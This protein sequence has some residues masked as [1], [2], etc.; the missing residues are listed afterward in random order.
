MAQNGRRPC[1]VV[2]RSGI[3]R[4]K[5]PISLVLLLAGALAL[6]GCGLPAAGP[7][8]NSFAAMSADS[9]TPPIAVVD[10]TPRTLASQKARPTMSLAAK[11]GALDRRRIL[12]LEPGDVISLSLWEAP[13]GTL[14]SSSILS[15]QGNLNNTSTITIPSQSVEADGSISVPFAGR[16]FVAGE[17]I[18]AVEEKISRALQG[19][20][21]Q[22]QALVTVVRSSVNTVTVTGE[23]AGGSRVPLSAGGERILDVIAASGGLRAPVH[24]SV[25]ELT[26]QRASARIPFQKLIHSP[27]EN[28]VLLPG[29]VVAVVREPQRFSVLGATGRNDDVIFDAPRISMAQALAKAGGLQDVRADATGVFLYRIEPIAVAAQLLPPDSPYLDAGA[30]FVPIVY[31]FNLLDPQTILAISHFWIQPQDVVYVSNAPAADLQKFLVI[32]QGIVGPAL[33]G[34]AIAVAAR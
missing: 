5:V 33:N 17:T 26:R 7:A 9:V 27:R 14:F 15:S 1:F 22:P 8:S 16:I 23:V 30:K 20:A 24:E 34:A 28:L 2:K 18:G 25:V 10:V 13:P 32:I 21:V 31:R 6:S 12:T 11:F 4:R 29:D 3:S 19:K